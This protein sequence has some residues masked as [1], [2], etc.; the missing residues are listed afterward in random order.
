M[1]PGYSCGMHRGSVRIMGEDEERFYINHDIIPHMKISS[2]LY[3][4][5]IVYLLYRA[6]L[7]VALF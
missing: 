4:V 6:N 1:S 2:I 7:D 5:Y 3:S